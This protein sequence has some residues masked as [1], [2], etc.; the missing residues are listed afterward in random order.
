MENLNTFLPYDRRY[1]I[2]NEVEVPEQTTGAALLVDISGYSTITTTLAHTLGPQRGSEVMTH[3]LNQLYSLLIG[4]VHAFQG[5]VI[6]YG[7]DALTCWFDDQFGLQNDYHFSGADRAVS[8]ALKMQSIIEEATTA[9]DETSQSI[10][11]NIKISVTGGQVHRLLVGDPKIQYFEIIAGRVVDRLAVAENLIEQGEIIIGQEILTAV[12]NNLHV[13]EWRQSSTD[14]HFAII[15]NQ[16]PTILP[17]PWV[18]DNNIDKNIA[19]KW[20]QDAIYQKLN[21][22]KQSIYCRVTT[23]GHTIY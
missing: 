13:Q 23:D 19:K 7:G 4:W 21:D 10:Q 17:N 12:K 3:H 20:L 18:L 8:C 16:N 14:E 2:L 22:K 5:S 15:S 6:I 9:Y 11:F 1:S